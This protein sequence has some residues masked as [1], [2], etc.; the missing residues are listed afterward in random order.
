MWEQKYE[1][2]FYL[3]KTPWIIR[4]LFSDLHWK[5]RQSDSGKTAYLTFDDGPTPRV[6]T[7]VLDTLKEYDAKATF[8]C[9]GKNVIENKD[10]YQR[11]IEEGHKV[12]NHTFEHTSGYSVN[13][14]SYI[15]EVQ[16]TSHYIES[17]L[18]RPPYGRIRKSQIRMLKDNYHIIMWDVLSGDFDT[19]ITPEKCIDNVLKNV[20][21]GSIIVFHDSKK[22]YP[23]LKIA[24]PHILSAMDKNGYRFAS[25]SDDTFF[26]RHI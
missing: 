9:L 8:F 17:N 23:A 24:L 12:G 2:I 1:L 4:T 16:K 20:D 22:A 14:E 5:G 19:A 7:W 13:A 21:N 25:L 15:E 18:F 3:S 26:D 6:T 11:I 10:I